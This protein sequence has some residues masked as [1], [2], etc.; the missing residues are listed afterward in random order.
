MSFKLTCPTLMKR[1]YLQNLKKE[2]DAKQQ[3]RARQTQKLCEAQRHLKQD[4]RQLDHMSQEIATFRDRRRQ[5]TKQNA[6]Q[7]K[8][9]QVLSKQDLLLWH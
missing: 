6:A 3:E 5:L 1:C 4:E 9:I 2:R 8:Q 7:N